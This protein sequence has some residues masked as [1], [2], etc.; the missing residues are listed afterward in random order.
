MRIRIPN[1]IITRCLI[2][3][4]I[5]GRDNGIPPYSHFRSF[6]NLPLVRRF[7]DLLGIMTSESIEKLRSVYELIV[8]L[9]STSKL[10]YMISLK[11]VWMISIYGWEDFSKS[12][13]VRQMLLVLL[14][15]V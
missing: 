10:I 13:P 1:L 9:K 2:F 15:L 8:E 5:L 14:F 6:C 12:Q 7:D 3:Y 4:K 11:E